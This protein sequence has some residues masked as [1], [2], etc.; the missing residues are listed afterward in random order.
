MRK[1]IEFGI[2]PEDAI[3]AA[4]ITPA[5]SI[6]AYPQIGVLQAGS[7]ADVLI[8]DNSFNLEQVL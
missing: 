8:L 4:T 3:K 6:K 1:A 5:K 7:K 2:A